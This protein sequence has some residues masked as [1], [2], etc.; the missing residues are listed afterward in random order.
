MRRCGD[1]LRGVLL[2]GP[3]N[4]IVGGSSGMEAVYE[5]IRRPRRRTRPWCSLGETGTGKELVAR[6]IHD[7]GPRASAPSSPSTAPPCP[8]ACSRASSS[9]TS[10]A[11]SPARRPAH[12][13]L[14]AGRRRHAVPGRDRRDAAGA[15]GQAAAR[16]PGATSSSA[17]ASS[18]TLH[19]DV[20]FIAATNHDLGGAGREGRLPPRSL[21]YRIRVVELSVPS[22]RERGPQD[23]ERLAEHFLDDVRA[24][25]PAQDS[26][27]W[28][29]GDAALE[30]ARLAGNARA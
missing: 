24:S 4:N 3:F 9:A 5:R 2:D 1:R 10:A 28:P 11:R 8:T 30:G 13:T 16:P 12:R 19:V 14:R 7:N 22:L 23:I 17:W 20:R 29:A 27:D 18:E 25:L 6:A 15:A 21:Y 26:R